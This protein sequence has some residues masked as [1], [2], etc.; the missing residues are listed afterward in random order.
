MST[1]GAASM[2]L[3]RLALL[4]QSLLLLLLLLLLFL[5]LLN[6]ELDHKMTGAIM[7]HPLGL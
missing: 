1:H 3:Q 6:C 5:L 2:L 4:P 7:P